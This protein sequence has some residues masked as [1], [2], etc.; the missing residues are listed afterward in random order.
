MSRATPT[1]NGVKRTPENR[2]GRVPLLAHLKVVLGGVS[3][4]GVVNGSS[5]NL[6]RCHIVTVCL[7]QNLRG[8]I[9][10]KRGDGRWS[11]VDCAQEPNYRKLA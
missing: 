6:G 8:M 11:L 2:A 10:E 1:L 5:S 4:V 9:D 3:G 7:K